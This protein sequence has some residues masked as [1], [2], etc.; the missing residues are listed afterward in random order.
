MLS[1]Q[2][3]RIWDRIKISES[4]VRCWFVEEDFPITDISRW[5]E[6]SNSTS[7]QYFGYCPKCGRPA[8]RFGESQSLPGSD[9]AT[10]LVGHR[11]E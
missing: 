6:N 2:G 11:L 4:R 7:L 9:F 10:E 5:E 8:V 3:F 1:D